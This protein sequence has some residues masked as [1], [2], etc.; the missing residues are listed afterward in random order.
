M[1]FTFEKKILEWLQK[2]ITPLFLIFITF[3]SVIIRFSL[4]DGISGDLTGFLLPWF[5]EIKAYGGFSTLSQQIGDYNIPYQT[6][7]A[8]FTYLPFEPTYMYKFLSCTFDY[9]LAITVGLIV[10]SFSN[11][12]RQFRGILAYCCIILSPV[13]FFN[14]SYWAQCDAIFS[15][16]SII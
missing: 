12:N 2:N 14:S 13:V 1:I 8:C 16:F 11:E 7:I 15:F 6:I 4:L 9:L 5:E 10:Y 3:L